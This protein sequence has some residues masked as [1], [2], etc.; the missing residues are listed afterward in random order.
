MALTP[1]L[2]DLDTWEKGAASSKIGPTLDDLNTW[3][4][5]D[6]QRPMWQDIAAGI[7]H[8]PINM[9]NFAL[10]GLPSPIDMTTGQPTTPRTIPQIPHSPHG[11]T[12]PVSHITSGI[13]EG[14][15]PFSMAARGAEALGGAAMGLSDIARGREAGTLA[16]RLSTLKGMP[17]LGRI[18]TSGAGGALTAAAMSDPGHRKTAAAVGGAG[19]GAGEL[20]AAPLGMAF[21]KA[22]DLPATSKLKDIASKTLQV[23]ETP[24]QRLI[25]RIGEAYIAARNKSAPLYEK[26]FGELRARKAGMK[27]KDF[28]NYTKLRGS[29]SKEGMKLPFAARPIED[30]ISEELGE[31]TSATIYS[32]RSEPL[33]NPKDVHRLQSRLRSI[34]RN[35]GDESAS[36][37][38]H[39]LR[40]DLTNFL[41]KEGLGTDY[42]KATSQFKQDVA[43]FLRNDVVS[44]HILPKI[45]SEIEAPE[46][47]G[48]DFDPEGR[49]TRKFT[50]IDDVGGKATNIGKTL[51]PKGDEKDMEK[52]DYL[53]NIL[54]HLPGEEAM[55][56]A[57]DNIFLHTLRLNPDTG[58]MMADPNMATA[59]YEKLGTQQKEKL[60]TH[61]ER[62]IF[63]TLVK[64]K[65]ERPKTHRLTQLGERILASGVGHHFGG[66]PGALAGY[67]SGPTI[68][69]II[70]DYAREMTTSDP[71]L[72]M[73]RIRGAIPARRSRFLAPLFATT[74]PKFAGTSS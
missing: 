3:D 58:E 43:P 12:Y 27:Q 53:E 5:G 40:K 57:R 4:K 42:E 18:G 55:K 46:T 25:N 13:V 44:K 32:G 72:L 60:F 9:L 1:T 19:G 48:A 74:L 35:T 51:V 38:G 8:D 39:A 64:I 22:R 62:K 26:L 6:V 33:V 21:R 23:F 68:G 36:A 11:W 34:G 2:S 24:G 54:G 49:Y 29:V 10:K 17:V 28:S 45:D 30:M 56:H 65:K 47:E 7:T 59:R 61:Q 69:D 73:E 52:L 50:G 63:D 66:W 20:L 31:P 70:H 16:R 37:L 15:L 67:A 14:A 41:Q 71:Q